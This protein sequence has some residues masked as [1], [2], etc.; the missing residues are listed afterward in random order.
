[1]ICLQYMTEFV[2]PIFLKKNLINCEL[3]KPDEY[4]QQKIHSLI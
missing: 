3:N 2:T 1:M 4:M